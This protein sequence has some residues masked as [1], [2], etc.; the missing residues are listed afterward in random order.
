MHNST[1]T[2]DVKT[3]LKS[4]NA[5]FIWALALSELSFVQ[6]RPYAILFPGLLLCLALMLKS[7][8]S[9]NMSLDL[10]PSFKTSVDTRVEGLVSIIWKIGVV[11]LFKRNMAEKDVSRAYTFHSLDYNFSFFIDILHRWWLLKVKK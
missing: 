11:I 5:E 1:E 3:K 6:F 9:T 10:M 4:I 2:S 7:T 8:K